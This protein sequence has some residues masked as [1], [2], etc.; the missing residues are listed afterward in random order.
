M[1]AHENERKHHL[2]ENG[3]SQFLDKEFIDDL[4][5]HGEGPAI[6]EVMEGTYIA[7]ASATPATID[8]LAACKAHPKSKSLAAL[9]DV[10]QRYKI[11]KES[12]SLRKEKTCTYN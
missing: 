5:L 6:T 4:G 10:V 8:F 9:P 12:W 7:P 1:C 3:T 2:T 11:Q